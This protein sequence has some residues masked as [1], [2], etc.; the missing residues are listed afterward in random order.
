MI[1]I[2][3]WAFVIIGLD[4]TDK[5]EL[6]RLE[7]TTAHYFYALQRAGALHAERFYNGTGALN[8]SNSP[9]AII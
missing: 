4:S 9:T 6:Y 1:R 2:C 7:T 3:A 5:A 8:W